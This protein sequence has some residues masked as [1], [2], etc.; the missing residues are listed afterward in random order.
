M[1]QTDLGAFELR[2][3]IAAKK[4]SPVEVLDMCV[5]QIERVNGHLNAIITM[6]IDRAYVAARN[7]EDQL[8]KNDGL[9]LLHGLPIAIK[10]LNRTRGM[11]TTFGSRFFESH[12]PT[13]DDDV[14]ERIRHHGAIIVGKTNTPEFGAGANT[15]NEV[16]GATRNPFDSNLTCG[17]SSGGGAVALA[18]R[19]VPLANGSDFGGSLRI[20]AGYCGV[21]GFRPSPGLVA[22]S[23]RA[24]LWSPW[25][26]EGAMGRNVDDTV[27]Q[28]A[29]IAGKS[30][31]DP[32][33]SACVH[34][35]SSGV[36]VADLSALRVAFSEDL[37]AASV[38]KIVRDKFREITKLL[39]ENF[40]HCSFDEP[41]TKGIHEAFRTIRGLAFVSNYGELYKQDRDRLGENTRGNV[42]DG[43]GMKLEDV[44]RADLTISTLYRS[45]QTFF[46][47]H[48]LLICPTFSVP[49]FPVDQ[50]YVSEID[51]KPMA[52]YFEW[53]ALT[54]IITLC[55][56]PAIS[57]PIGSIN[58]L[59]FSIQI[60]GR[61]REDISLLKISK[62]VENLI[63][64][65]TCLH[66]PI[67]KV[68]NNCSDKEINPHEFPK[69]AVLPGS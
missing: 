63:R 47:N 21:V 7:A 31:D 60:V 48:D 57:I 65:E 52:N 51:G 14:V 38:S 10:D 59:P 30:R 55:G 69:Q 34:D 18:A 56:H 23:T 45:F 27:L 11:R 12:V 37:G 68:H 39:A 22:C 19:M 5:R 17:G 66:P 58:G 4:I 40:S 50:L 54:Y 46:E 32:F 6:D 24:Q 20:P 16:F 49:A 15:T 25:F 13:D 41:D 1:T 3:M 61:S 67:A 33:S 43:L 36:E 62:A 53:F 44:A 8:M 26:V 35:L 64:N 29:A 42:E 28:L 2:Q 9:G